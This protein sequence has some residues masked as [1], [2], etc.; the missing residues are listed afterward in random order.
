MIASTGCCATSLQLNRGNAYRC[1][2]TIVTN[3]TTTRVSTV[4]PA[5]CNTSQP[6]HTGFSSA[7]GAGGGG[8]STGGGNCSTTRGTGACASLLSGCGSNCGFSDND[9]QYILSRKRP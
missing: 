3:C 2:I 7:F 5:I 1:A 9:R 8:R 6:L 4:S